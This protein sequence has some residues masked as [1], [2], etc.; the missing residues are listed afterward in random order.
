MSVTEI[1]E[2]YEFYKFSIG[3]FQCSYTNLEIFGPEVTGS[4]KQ[5]KDRKQGSSSL[6]MA[7]IVNRFPCKFKALHASYMQ[8]DSTTS[9]SMRWPILGLNSNKN[10]RETV[11]FN[12]P[13]FSPF[14]RAVFSGEIRRGCLPSFKFLEHTDSPHHQRSV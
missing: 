6:S 11:I 9:N 3:R 12:V 5:N 13:S 2:E 7:G 8:E 14:A 1:E 10:H 4:N